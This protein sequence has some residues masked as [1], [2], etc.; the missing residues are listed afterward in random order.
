MKTVQETVAGNAF[1]AH[2]ENLLLSILSDDDEKIRYH[3]WNKILS[4][5]NKNSDT[6]QIRQFKIPKLNFDANHYTEL[7]DWENQAASVPPI[8]RNFGFGENDARILAKKKL[9]DHELGFNIMEIPCHTQS[10]ERCVK[11]VTEASGSVC[12]EERRD[13]LI[14][15]KLQSQKDMPKLV[16]KRDFKVNPCSSKQVPV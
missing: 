14:I 15:N 9:C 7:I 13:G 4:I 11:A 16:N 12:G 6:T 5:R 10:V 8:L 3:G 2:P 1:F